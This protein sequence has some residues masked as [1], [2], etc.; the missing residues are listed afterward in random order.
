MSEI[1]GE[2][3][4]LASLIAAPFEMLPQPA[5]SINGTWLSLGW[6]EAN[7]GDDEDGWYLSLM[8]NEDGHDWELS[9]A[10]ADDPDYLLYVIF[11]EVTAKLAR[12]EAGDG[13][14]AWFGSQKF[15][16]GRLNLQWQ[17]RTADRHAEML[18]V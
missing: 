11:D 4:R 1:H 3:R 14:I 5:K 7:D 10:G 12:R 9:E 13:R 18:Q 8:R 15:M 16:L 2:V 17:K 6:R